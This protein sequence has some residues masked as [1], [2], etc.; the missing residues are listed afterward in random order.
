MVAKV[1]TSIS[2]SSIAD[3]NELN[4]FY[5]EAGP[6]TNKWIPH[7]LNPITVNAKDC[8]KRRSNIPR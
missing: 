5:S 2:N 8:E 6:V 3:F 4:I 7:K 1:I